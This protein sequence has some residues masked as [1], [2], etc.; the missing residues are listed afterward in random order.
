MQIECRTTSLLGCYAEMQFIFCKN[1]QKNDT[2]RIICPKCLF[3]Y[4]IKVRMRGNLP[5]FQSFMLYSSLVDE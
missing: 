4:I 5:L 3:L 1:K 2:K